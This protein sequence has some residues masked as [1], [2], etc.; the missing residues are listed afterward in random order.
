MS[1]T[2]YTIELEAYKDFQIV[3]IDV[4]RWA[5]SVCRKIKRA[6]QILEQTMELRAACLPGNTKLLKFA[7]ILGYE[8]TYEEVSPRDGLEYL[9]L[10]RRP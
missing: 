4:Y 1:E 8:H 10:T 2:D 5:P 7:G 3:H 9:I 6:V